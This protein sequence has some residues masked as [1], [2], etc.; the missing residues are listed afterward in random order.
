MPALVVRIVLDGCGEESVDE[1]GLSQAGFTSDLAAK[2]VDSTSQNIM[3]KHTMMV[4]AAPLLATILC[5]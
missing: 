5:R 4:N 2:S 3:I 1:G